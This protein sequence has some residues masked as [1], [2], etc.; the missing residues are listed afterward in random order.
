VVIDQTAKAEWA[1]LWRPLQQQAEKGA[2]V[3]T[4]RDYHAENLIW[5]PERE[6]AARV[7]LLDFQDALKAHPVWDLTM[8][9]HDAR[10]DVSPMLELRALRRYLGKAEIADPMAFM[11]DFHAIGSLNIVRIIGVF[12]RLVTRDHKPRYAEFIP[13]MWSYLNHCLT[14]PGMEEL[15]VWFNTYVPLEVRK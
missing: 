1:G 13:R 15:E 6:G 11:A 4:H 7:G 10:R 14:R 2:G 12:A 9:L 5:L 3:F 8:L